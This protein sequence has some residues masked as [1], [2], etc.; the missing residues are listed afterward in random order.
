MSDGRAAIVTGAASG[1]GRAIAA[2]LAPTARRAGG[3]PEA[4]DGPGTPF[5]ADL[6]T[7]EGNRAAVDAAL[8]R[9]GRIDAVVANAGFQHVAPVARVPRG[10]L[11]RADRAPAHQPVPARQVRLAGAGGA[12]ATGASS[13]SRR[14]TGWPPRRSRP[15]TCRQ[16]RRARPGQDARA[17]GRGRRHPR[18]RGVPRLRAHPARRGPDRAAGP[19]ARDARG[20]RARRGDPGPARGQAPDRARRGRR[21][22]RLPAGPGGRAF[23]ARRS[24]DLGWTAR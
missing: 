17:G 4:D 10:P 24:M 16:A 18:H 14:R 19:G 11:G 2:R 12:P 3:G 13:P 21:G 20:A 9:F 23:R 15:A 1:I 22:G 7:R 5:A 8:E 6:T